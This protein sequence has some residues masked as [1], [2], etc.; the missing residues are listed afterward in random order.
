VFQ[1]EAPRFLND[2]IIRP[3]FHVSPTSAAEKDVAS[4]RL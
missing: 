3:T 2:D 1:P 4:D